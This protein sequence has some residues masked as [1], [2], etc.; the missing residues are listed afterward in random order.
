MIPA[1]PTCLFGGIHQNA[2]LFY[3]GMVHRPD[4]WASDIGIFIFRGCIVWQLRYLI[5]L[6][7]WT[8]QTLY[9]FGMRR[10]CCASAYLVIPGALAWSILD[11]TWYKLRHLHQL[12]VLLW[13]LQ[14]VSSGCS[15]ARFLGVSLAFFGAKALRVSV[16]LWCACFTPKL[17]GQSSLPGNIYGIV[18]RSVKDFLFVPGCVL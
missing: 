2:C 18:N 6:A 15:W 13:R 14:S 9:S 12:G 8:H 11:I 7:S 5:L 3:W 4:C 16:P 17:L 1:Q 10:S